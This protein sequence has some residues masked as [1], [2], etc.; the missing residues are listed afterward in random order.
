MPAARAIRYKS[1]PAT[2]GTDRCDSGLSTSIAIAGLG[3]KRAV[4]LNLFQ[5]L[6]RKIGRME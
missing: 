6:I 2:V 4:I 3:I 5:D 1:F